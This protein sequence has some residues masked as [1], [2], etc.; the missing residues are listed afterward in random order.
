MHKPNQYFKFGRQF[1]HLKI[2]TIK[3]RLAKIDIFAD[4]SILADRSIQRNWWQYRLIAHELQTSFV[5]LLYK[6]FIRQQKMDK[7]VDKVNPF[8]QIKCFHGS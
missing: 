6:M 7:Q 1:T 2:Y 8:H 5:K 4:R 3:E